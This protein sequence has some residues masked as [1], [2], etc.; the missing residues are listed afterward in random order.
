MCS[1]QCWPSL[2]LT[3]WQTINLITLTSDPG[4][5]ALSSASSVYDHNLSNTYYQ[6]FWTPTSLFIIF[7]YYN[8][9]DG[10]KLKA[11]KATNRASYTST[12]KKLLKQH[13][14]S[15]I[16]LQWWLNLTPDCWGDKEEGNKAALG[17]REERFRQAVDISWL[18][19]VSS[20]LISG[21]ICWL[22]STADLLNLDSV[23]KVH[24]SP[25]STYTQT[26]SLLI[27]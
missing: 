25:A 1:Q 23:S 3:V 24:S 21:I 26:Y 19:L 27:H 13:Y 7:K 9:I 11:L 18:S 22:C 14:L 10:M 2:L 12:S 6:I 4:L 8:S 5:Q 15:A 17:V 20:A 16:K